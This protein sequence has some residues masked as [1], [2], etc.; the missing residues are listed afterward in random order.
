[1]E[2]GRPE[3]NTRTAIHQEMGRQDRETRSRQLGRQV[4]REIKQGDKDVREEDKEGIQ[5]GRQPDRDIR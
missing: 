4:D 2:T 1:M 5:T 3:E